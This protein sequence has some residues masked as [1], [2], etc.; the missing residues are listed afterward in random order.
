LFISILF[1]EEDEDVNHEN[2]IQ[3][4]FALATALIIYIA[5][6][7]LPK[8]I[9][10]K[11][12][13]K[14]MTTQLLEL[15]LSLIAMWLLGKG[16][17]SD[18]GFRLPVGESGRRSTLIRWLLIGIIAVA[19]GA[20]ATLAILITGAI[21]NPL[22]KELNIGQIILF[23]WIFSSCI[24]E[25][26]TRGF[27]QSHLA[28][29]LGSEPKI[30]IL[31]VDR[32]TFISALFFASMHLVILKSGADIKSAVIIVLFTFIVGLLAGNERSRSGSLIPAIGVHMLA[33]IGG[34]IGGVIYGIYAF[35]TGARI[36]MP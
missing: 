28:K 13:L 16:R 12:V 9:F 5:A 7:I 26:F 6:V 36:P 21:G 33:N 19:V 10:G 34:L 24:E 8:F 27:L 31:R 15:G 22:V 1:S 4:I 17:F 30:P 32:P 23:I 2:R 25:I 11:P 14:I 20:L 3:I 29:A 35:L 18:Y